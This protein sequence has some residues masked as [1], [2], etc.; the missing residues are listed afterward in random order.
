MARSL[1]IAAYLA[2]LGSVERD[3]HQQEQPP[4]PEGTIIW[5]RCCD[6]D[7]LMS[8]ETL[9]RRLAEKGD[10]VSIVATLRNWHPALADR[11]LPEPQGKADIRAFI[12]HWRPAMV[13]WVY[14]ELD[15][16]L[17]SEMRS[18]G[19]QCILVDASA[20]GLNTVAGR[21]IPGVLRILL[22][23][24]EAVLALDQTAA[25]RLLRAGAPAAAVSVTGAMEDCAPTLPG[26]ESKRSAL[27][28]AIGTRT[29]W[30]AAAAHLNEAEDLCLAQQEASKR[31]HRL[32][33]IVVPKTSADAESFAEIMRNRGL[34]VSLRSI[35]PDPPE[36]AQIY[37]ADT[38][39]NL[40]LWYR[41]A[42]VCYMGGSLKGGGCRD[43]F[44]ATALGSVVIYGPQIAPFQRHALDRK[45]VV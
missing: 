28:R 35:D 38:D 26:N 39:E 23:E 1:S 34:H 14:G 20:E 44:E 5:A 19:L 18:A 25:D 27:A 42:P 33:L 6:P 29:V 22:A 13:V 2:G 10:P 32:L 40:G 16:I 31:A 11:A 15:P 4:R 30:L 21:W 8:V 12:A 9:G 36:V 7:Q 24:F 41:I 3:P 43:P 17:M 45:S 37:I